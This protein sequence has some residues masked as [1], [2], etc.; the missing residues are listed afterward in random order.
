MTAVVLALLATALMQ[1]GYLGWKVVADRRVTAGPAAAPLLATGLWWWGALAVMAG[2]VLFVAATVNGDISVVQPVMSVGD[3]LLVLAAVVWLRERLQPVEWAGVALAIAGV[4]ILSGQAHAARTMVDGGGLA[5]VCALAVAGG[6][7]LEIAGRGRDALLTAVQV[8]A[9][10][11]L[12]ALLTKSCAATVQAGEGALVLAGLQAAGVLAANGVGLWRLQ[13][14]FQHG[15]AAVVVPLV[16]AV[17]NLVAVL[18]GALALGEDVNAVRALAV[19]VIVAGTAAFLLRR[20][21]PTAP[22]APA[23]EAL[24]GQGEQQQDARA[25]GRGGVVQ[26]A[27]QQVEPGG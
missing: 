12:G 10:F 19:A 7:A 17:A 27:G 21:V 15:R 23:V 6:I 5:A 3:L 16:L 11:G 8:G 1:C 2:W 18:G 26:P 20:P 4:F 25:L 13:S 22:S 9:G 24:P 14:A